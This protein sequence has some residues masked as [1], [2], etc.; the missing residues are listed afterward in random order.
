M[1]CVI[2]RRFCSLQNKPSAFLS[3]LQ[4]TKGIAGLSSETCNIPVVLKAKMKTLRN[5]T[6]QRQT[7]AV[8]RPSETTVSQQQ[9]SQQ[10]CHNNSVTTTVSQQQCHNNSV[11]SVTTTM[12]Q[13]Q[14][15][16]NCVT[17]T[18]S[19]QQCHNNNVTT[20]VSQQQ[21]HKFHNNSVTTKNF[22]FSEETFKGLKCYN[23][24]RVQRRQTALQ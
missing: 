9:V 20:T 14:C 17:T 6:N 10:Q 22:Y 5:S 3:V 15:H 16:N 1:V 13:Q 7:P 8:H 2:H 21:C 24:L 4:Q 19:Q 18:V 12:S 23:L 11:T